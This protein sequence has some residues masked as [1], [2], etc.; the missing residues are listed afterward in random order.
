MKKNISALY[1][2]ILITFSI[3]SIYAN[4]KLFEGFSVTGSLTC[5]YANNVFEYIP[6]TRLGSEP[7]V[8]FE[9]ATGQFGSIA[10]GAEIS[11]A[12]NWNDRF[13]GISGF[14]MM[15]PR[16]NDTFQLHKAYKNASSQTG[17]YPFT[18]EQYFFGGIVE[19][20]FCSTASHWVFISTGGD[21][22]TTYG[23]PKFHAS[24]G[25]GPYWRIIKTDIDELEGTT[26]GWILSMRYQYLLF[27]G[28]GLE[29]TTRAFFEKPYW[30][31]A[32]LTVGLGAFYKIR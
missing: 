20:G 27:K 4:D 28:L 13:V 32:T 8:K 31:R 24:L 5:S 2:I 23:D 15:A 12:Y 22:G 17:E 18:L 11:A 1:I 21:A 29:A 14:G 6:T 3:S 9:I 16:Y 26:T 19:A 25:A 10:P 7:N 30:D